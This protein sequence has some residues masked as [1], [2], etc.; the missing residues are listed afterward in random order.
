MAHANI[1]SRAD[2]P[3]AIGSSMPRKEDLALLLGSARFAGDVQRPGMAFAHVVR[4][5]VAHALVRRVDAERARRAPGVI[6]VLTARDLP[7]ATPRIPM[8]MFRHEGLSRFLQP[9][10]AADRVRYS[11]EPLAVIVAESRYLAE[12]A[13]EQLVVDLDPLEPVLDAEAAQ[14][15]DAALLHPDAGTNLA[16]EFEIAFGDLDDAFARADHVIEARIACHRHGAVPMETRGLVAEVD[17]VDGTLTVWGAAK[18]PH[19]NRRILAG[20]L[21]W[22]EERIRLVEV[23]VGGAFGARGEFYPE[24]FLIPLCAIRCGRPVGWVEDR[25]E[26]MRSSNHSRE[27]LHEVAIALDADGTFVALRDRLVNDTGAYVRT[28][29]RLVPNMTAAF[30]PGPYRWAAYRCEAR[31]VVTNK[32]PAGAY[33]APGRYEANYVRE[34]I[35]DIA[36]HRLGLDPVEIRARNLLGPQDMPH[37]IGTHTDGHAQTY[38]TGDYPALLERAVERFDLARMR[39]WRAAAPDGTRRGI[40][41]C[42]FV[43]KGAVG[44]WEY[45]RVE[46]DS[47]GQPHVY[48]GSV[49]LGQGLETVLAQICADALGVAYEDIT[50]H[51]GDTA[52]VPDGMGSYG[53]RSTSLGGSAVHLAAL[54]LRERVLSLAAEELDRDPG[55]LDIEG[56][57]V[58]VTDEPD[59]SISLMAL[60]ERARPMATVGTG[61]RPGL[62]EEEYATCMESSFPYGVHLAAVEVDL[63]TGQVTLPRYLIAYD[64]GRAVNPM[65][66]EGQLVGGA[67]QGIAGALLEELSYSAEGQLVSGSFLDFLMP[68]AGDVPAI[69]VLLCE[70]APTGL[71]P[72]Q[73]K[74][75]GEGGTAGAGGAVANAVADAM[76]AEVTT[77][78]LTPERVLGLTAL[79]LEA[80]S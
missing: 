11:G 67:A 77:L 44:K 29:G 25:E 62:S 30:L 22:A 70:D 14:H 33:R 53:S 50:V 51:H 1:A 55:D 66:V 2:L 26:H 19:V 18:V 78:P 76:G 60:C 63:E 45:G 10:L 43:E 9:V 68:T 3:S 21:G 79:E 59:R 27:Q 35:V 48:S 54:R 40:G 52:T 65:L 57:A 56:G 5:P 23:H 64:V 47:R 72:L 41:L 73:V 39:S 34:R 8:R 42:F 69:E 46:L 75:A 49:S 37:P 32:T 16:T 20:M 4:S 58:V 38:D 80:L 61:R 31:H 36:A 17:G 24:D 13:A 7:D 71:N 28:Q 74:G 12:D 15:A 6:D